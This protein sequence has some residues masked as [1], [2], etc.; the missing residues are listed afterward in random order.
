MRPGLRRHTSHESLISVS[1]MDIH[2]LQSRPSQLLYSNAARFATPG[3]SGSVGPELTPWTATA[4][5]TLSNKTSRSSML[6]RDLLYSSIANQKRG[7]RKSDGPQ[8]S[9]GPDITKR[10]GGWVFSKWGASPAPAP[11]PT[12]PTATATRAPSILSQ[13]TKST[14]D[15]QSNEGTT[16]TRDDAGGSSSKTKDKPKL[17]PSGVNQNG[18]IWGF[19]DEFPDAP[20]KV[21]V[22]DYDREALGEALAEAA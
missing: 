8:P 4:H 11:A 13:E 17:R 6:N 20:A 21:V 18:P 16:A 19:F 2:T 9:S 3:S 7:P 14:Q 22:Q 5:G 12:S 15:T 10:V 1:G